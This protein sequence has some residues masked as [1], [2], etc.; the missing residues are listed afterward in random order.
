MAF[1]HFHVSQV[2]AVVFI[3]VL[4]TG[5]LEF[6]LKRLTQSQSRH[7][8]Q[9]KV[10]IQGQIKVRFQLQSMEQCLEAPSWFAFPMLDGF[11]FY[12]RP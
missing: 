10:Q 2:C 6:G 1:L 7:C 8:H 9:S 4:S 11:C 3:I 12:Q 5:N